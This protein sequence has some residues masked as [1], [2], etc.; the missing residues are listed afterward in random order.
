MR[1][2]GLLEPSF[3]GVQVDL[4]FGKNSVPSHSGE[5]FDDDRTSWIFPHIFIRR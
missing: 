5:R 3:R 1:C 2:G 4:A